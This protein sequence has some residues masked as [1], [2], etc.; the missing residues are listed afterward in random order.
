MS[1]FSNEIPPSEDADFIRSKAKKLDW[2]FAY[3]TLASFIKEPV[4]SM[5]NELENWFSELESFLDGEFGELIK[6]EFHQRIWELYC[7]KLLG[8]RFKLSKKAENGL[9]DFLARIQEDEVWLEATAPDN[10]RDEHG[11]KLFLMRDELAKN[12]HASYGGLISE[13]TDPIVLRTKA[14]IQKKYE[15]YRSTYTANGVSTD[16]PFMIAINSYLF[17]DGNYPDQ[18]ILHLFFEMGNQVVFFGKNSGSA[19]EGI[20]RE[21]RN[22]AKSLKGD[23]VAVGMFRSNQYAEISAIIFTPKDIFNLERNKNR[24][25]SDVF[26]IFNPFAKNKISPEAFSFCTRVTA[27]GDGVRFEKP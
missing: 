14:A 25:G 3:A 11:N 26:V 5:K 12:G 20:F 15:S 17:D 27:E 24:I 8:E 1:L 23:Q 4:V 6:K 13:R 21:Q 19:P 2:N 10:G 22:E 9:P 16:K 7:G 18:A